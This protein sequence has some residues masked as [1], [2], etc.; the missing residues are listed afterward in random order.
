M[1]PG[2]HL[3]Q[4][5]PLAVVIGVVRDIGRPQLQ[6]NRLPARAAVQNGRLRVPQGEVCITLCD[7]GRAISLVTSLDMPIRLLYGRRRVSEQLGRGARGHETGTTGGIMRSLAHLRRSRP[8]AHES[9]SSPFS[10]GEKIAA[11]RDRVS[12]SSR[13]RERASRTDLI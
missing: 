10:A 4:T 11:D 5:A 2:R 1:L 12:A 3:V 13:K 7:E 6:V 8:V 9:D